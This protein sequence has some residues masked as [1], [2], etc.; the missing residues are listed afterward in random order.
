M[1]E[2]RAGRVRVARGRAACGMADS[3]SV[4]K[5]FMCRMAGCWRHTSRVDGRATDNRASKLVPVRRCRAVRCRWIGQRLEI[6]CAAA[7]A[8]HTPVTNSLVHA[9]CLVHFAVPGYLTCAHLVKHLLAVLLEA[10]QPSMPGRTH[11]RRGAA[12]VKRLAATLR[13]LGRTTPVQHL[14]HFKPHRICVYCCQCEGALHGVLYD[15]AAVRGGHACQHCVADLGNTGLHD[16]ARLSAAA[17]VDNALQRCCA[18]P[19][20][21]GG[22]SRRL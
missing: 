3:A 1:G 10:V 22:R 6:E 20:A 21:R 17:A 9:I 15:G 14:C 11:S 7:V 5:K 18:L 13:R 16:L 4:L 2:E 12:S 8:A 19:L